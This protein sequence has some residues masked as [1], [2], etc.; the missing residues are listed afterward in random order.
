MLLQDANPTPSFGGFGLSVDDRDR[1]I[2]PKAIQPHPI[3]L[4]AARAGPGSVSS[5][6]DGEQMEHAKPAARILV[7]DDEEPIQ[8][9][10]KASLSTAGYECDAAA[11]A[12]QAASMLDQGNYD[13]TLLDINMP[14]KSGIDF[15]PEL[16]AQHPDVAVLMLSGE[17]DLTQAVRTMREGAYDYALKPVGLAELVIR[18]ENALS[19]RA[20]TL[21]N[22]AYHHKQEEIID[23]L[24]ALLEQ[25]KRELSAL[26][27]LFQS[28][29]QQ[30]R[31]AQAEYD[32]LKKTLASFSTQLEGL[33]TVVGV[34]NT[35]EGA[36]PEYDVKQVKLSDS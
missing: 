8:R 14:G 28:H 1:V 36:P 35:Q 32:Q 10:L 15:L 18:I 12:D 34:A 7:V 17:T 11:G 26:N 30:T 31:S 2:D 4:P 25:R 3:A 9:S 16:R 6:K 22:R 33:A 23:Q 19:R 5:T 20:L 21:E 13:L 24:N 29:M 27:R